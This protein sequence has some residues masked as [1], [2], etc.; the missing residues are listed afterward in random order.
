M[1]VNAVSPGGE[2]THGLVRA[3]EQCGERAVR[4]VAV[5]AARETP[6]R[7]RR[8]PA[9]PPRRPRRFAPCSS[10]GSIPRPSPNRTETSSSGRR[11]R[12][13]DASADPA[14]GHPV[15]PVAR[16][17]RRRRRVAAVRGRLEPPE[18][19][20]RAREL[21]ERPVP[22]AVGRVP[23]RSPRGQPRPDDAGAGVNDVEPGRLADE[24]R[25]GRVAGSKH[26]P[27]AVAAALLLD[28][29]AEDEVAAELGA[30]LGE[31][32]GREQ[33]GREPTFHVAG[34]A[35]PDA[36]V[37]D[38]PGPGL[39]APGR[40]GVDR[41]HVHVAGQMQ[42]AAP[43]R[44]AP[45]ADDRAAAVVRR[46]R[47]SRRRVVPGRLGVGLDALHLEPGR[48]EPIRDHLLGALLV[49]ERALLADE[50]RDERPEARR[51]CGGATRRRSF[52]SIGHGRWHDRGDAASRLSSCL[53]RLFYP[54]PR[55]NWTQDA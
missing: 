50:L 39:V 18:R 14:H 2:P 17:R 36:P 37:G 29:G 34:A 49:P 42:R 48:R 25:V 30:G 7:R 24:R 26:G 3:P 45:D 27:H 12:R 15:R 51:S 53:R 20:D 44:S 6:R 16:P 35:P 55:T 40:V 5:G 22:A 19:G 41:H 13:P 21:V 38:L 28:H 10:A 47:D 23:G 9:R 52:E 46:W 1:A 54:P 33:V 4:L 11:R 31:R 8:P 32:L 43:G